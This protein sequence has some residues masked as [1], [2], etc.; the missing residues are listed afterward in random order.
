MGQV[1][2]AMK[3]PT[4]VLYHSGLGPT[5][6]KHKRKGASQIIPSLPLVPE[7]SLFLSLSSVHKN[8]G[9]SYLG[10][11]IALLMLYY[12]TNVSCNEFIFLLII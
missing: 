2:K 3:E 7:N 1:I 11:F 5:C 6:K 12:V 9:Q 8:L 4:S 10:L